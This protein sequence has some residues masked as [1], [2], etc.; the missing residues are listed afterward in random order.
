LPLQLTTVILKEMTPFA[1]NMSALHGSHVFPYCPGKCETRLHLL[2]LWLLPALVQCHE[3]SNVGSCRD[4]KHTRTPPPILAGLLSKFAAPVCTLSLPMSSL[5]W[6][7][8]Y[9]ISRSL[10][11]YMFSWSLPFWLF[12]YEILITWKPLSYFVWPTPYLFFGW[13]NRMLQQLPSQISMMPE[14]NQVS[15]FLIWI[16]RFLHQ[17]YFL[18]MFVS[19]TDTTKSS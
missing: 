4:S 8:I 15:S 7:C 14:H 16:G 3:L 19:V 5:I 18:C 12:M 2:R 1:L 10:H 9:L 6:Q 11:R 17:M 13:D